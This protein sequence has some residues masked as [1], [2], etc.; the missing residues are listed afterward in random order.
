MDGLRHRMKIIVGALRYVI[1]F[2]TLGLPW[3]IPRPKGGSCSV[4]AARIAK[5]EQL[6]HQEFNGSSIASVIVNLNPHGC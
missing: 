6:G 1:N 5:G 2:P 3:G 4:A